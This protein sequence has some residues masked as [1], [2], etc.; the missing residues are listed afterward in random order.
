MPTPKLGKPLRTRAQVQSRFHSGIE[1]LEIGSGNSPTAGYVHLDIQ[2]DLPKLNIVA[3]VRKLPLPDNFV[4]QEIR[5]IHIFEHFC[6]PQFASGQQRQKYG[7]T[8]EVLKE[9]YRV[10]KPGGKLKIVTPDLEK[11]ATSIV[12][13]RVGFNWLQQWLVGGHQDEYDHHHWLWTKR[14]AQTW[15][16]QVGFTNVKDWNPI[17][18]PFRVWQLKWHTPQVSGNIDWHK[19][20][21]YHW[22]FIEGQK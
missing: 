18:L 9:C 16:K 13:K 3:N 8:I 6:H 15:F 11:I 1:R 4:S 17:R 10:L 2:T 5:A 21:F 12:K 19:I 20:E 22:L 7:T 14:D